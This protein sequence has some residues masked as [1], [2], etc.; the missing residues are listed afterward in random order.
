MDVKGIVSQAVADNQ[1][2]GVCLN[3]VTVGRRALRRHLVLLLVLVAML[4]VA[5]AEASAELQAEVAPDVAW[6]RFVESYDLPREKV[7]AMAVVPD[8]SIVV[9]GIADGPFVARTADAE[10]A[11]TASAHPFFRKYDPDGAELW[12]GIS[13][14]MPGATISRSG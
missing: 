14:R 6:T 1:E 3:S 2:Y 4:V 11:L 5:G 12:T 7:S 10:Y 8:G 9:A 13:P